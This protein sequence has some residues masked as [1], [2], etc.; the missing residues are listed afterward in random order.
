MGGNCSNGWPRHHH[1]ECLYYFFVVRVKAMVV[2]DAGDGSTIG[3]HHAGLY[4]AISAQTFVWVLRMCL[5]K[6]HSRDNILNE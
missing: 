1:Q 4:C 2:I 3:N 5:Q 6:L